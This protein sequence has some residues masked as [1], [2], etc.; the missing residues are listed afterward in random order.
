MGDGWYGLSDGPDGLG[1]GFALHQLPVAVGRQAVPLL[2]LAP[3]PADGELAHAGGRP[4]AEEEARVARREVA[5][6]AFGE[7]RQALAIDLERHGRAGDRA[8]APAEQLHAQ[9]VRLAAR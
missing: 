9:P 3:R 5:A 1:R 4:Q 8:V 2:R 7:A 6:A